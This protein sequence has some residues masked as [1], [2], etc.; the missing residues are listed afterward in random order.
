MGIY[1]YYGEGNLVDMCNEQ[2]EK[3]ENNR[4]TRGLEFAITLLVALGSL[5]LYTKDYIIN[6]PLSDLR[7]IITV[8][9]LII[10]TTLVIGL[11]C[12]I[13]LKG[14]SIE[15]VNSSACTK[16]ATSASKLYRF[17]FLT[18]AV[19]FLYIF[20]SLLATL[21]LHNSSSFIVVLLIAIICTIIGAVLISKFEVS[22]DFIPKFITD[23]I[24]KQMI[25]PFLLAV[26]L[27]IWYLL[28]S[29]VPF[30]LQGHITIDMEN[31]YYNSDEHIPVLIQVTG[32]DTALSV[33]L[34]SITKDNNLNKRAF[35]EKLEPYPNQKVG[36][37]NSL[38]GYPLSS[39]KYIVYINTTNLSTGYYK[40][41]FTR[42]KN[43]LSDA[44]GF[45]LSNENKSHI[46][47]AVTAT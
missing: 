27:I 7:Y 43:K 44:K 3:D 2:P 10:A 42:A 30:T 32:P 45:Y 23:S 35:I 29:F 26:G 40:L 13:I 11:L 47:R 17:M 38:I 20:L 34:S 31:I 8:Y 5:I 16:L 24:P 28:W 25:V 6:N 4:D 9:L 37:D 22:M 15:E 36:H 21:I 41:E 1:L 39:G 14:Y 19:L 33:K 12:Y 18:S 46:S